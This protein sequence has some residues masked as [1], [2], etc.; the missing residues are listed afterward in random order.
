MEWFGAASN[1]PHMKRIV[2]HITPVY[3]VEA[4]HSPSSVYQSHST[5]SSP[6]TTSSVSTIQENE[7]RVKPMPVSQKKE[8]K[9]KEEKKEKKE[10]TNTDLPATPSIPQRATTT[11]NQ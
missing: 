10:T 4:G 3:Q 9:E 2:E 11:H 6:K 7:A 8:K 5:F 1:Y